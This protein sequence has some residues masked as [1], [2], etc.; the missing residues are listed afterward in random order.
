M[1]NGAKTANVVKCYFDE[2]L[3]KPCRA[4]QLNSARFKNSISPVDKPLTSTCG[5]DA[6]S[7]LRPQV[8]CLPRADQQKKVGLNHLSCGQP[9]PSVHLT[10]RIVS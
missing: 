5:T 9:H 7:A 3:G 2:S 10:H 6:P 8:A 1:A 4:S